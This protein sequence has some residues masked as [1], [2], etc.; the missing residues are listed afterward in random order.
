LTIEQL[1]DYLAPD[2]GVGASLDLDQRRNRVLVDEEVI[3]APALGS[4]LTIGDADLARKQDP[5]TWGVR[6]LIPGQQPRSTI[7]ASWRET[8]RAAYRIQED[9]HFAEALA[10][11]R[12]PRS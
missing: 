3:D 2:P 1:P 9:A 7:H 6:Q 11:S 10:W 5:A 8:N 4:A 12:S